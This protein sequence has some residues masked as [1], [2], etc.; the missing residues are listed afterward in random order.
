[1]HVP[2]LPCPIFSLSLSPSSSSLSVSLTLA[3][4]AVFRFMTK[5][6]LSQV[7][8]SRSAALGGETRPSTPIHWG[9]RRPRVRVLA[10]CSLN[11]EL[12]LF[13]C[14]IRV[15]DTKVEMKQRCVMSDSPSHPSLF[16]SLKI[17]YVRVAVP[18]MS[19]ES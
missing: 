4:Y 16:L 10:A 9:G 13:P 5:S 11:V 7:G 19:H 2:F 3:V 14:V 1:M 8:R 6:P 18:L 17:L 12:A 15:L